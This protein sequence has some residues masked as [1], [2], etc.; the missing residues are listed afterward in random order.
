MGQLP[1][2]RM[3][4]GNIFECVGIDYAGPILVK[5]GPIRKPIVTKAYIALFVSFT[6]KAVH[7][8]PVSDLTTAAFIA[9]LRRFVARRGK[10]STLWS[11]H[12]TNFVGAKR[13]LKELYDLLR[14]KQHQEAIMDY[15]TSQAMEWKFVPEHAPHFGGLWEAAVKSFKSHFKK[16]VGEV[17]LTFEELVTTTSQIEACLNSRPLTPLPDSEDGI[18]V[19]TPGHFLI[20]RPLEAIPD[21]SQDPPKSIKLLRRWQLCQGLVNHFWKR[22]S[23]EYLCHLNKFAKWNTSSP[24]VSVGDIVCLRQETTVPTKWPL[25]RVTKVYPGV[26]GKVRV[27]SVRTSKGIYNRPVVKI[28]PLVQERSSE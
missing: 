14:H 8:E 28:V 9:A 26:D 12:G 10:P 23:N 21:E 22:W 11:D 16:V 6:V 4:V 18:E 25:A 19:L 20:G 3:R 17:K 15:C 13:E 7:I 2:D 5:S 24:N 27:V 1:T